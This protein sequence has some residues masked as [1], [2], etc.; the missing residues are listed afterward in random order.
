[1][2]SRSITL[3]R[4]NVRWKQITLQ[5]FCGLLCSLKL[6]FTSVRT[7]TFLQLSEKQLKSMFKHLSM[8][9]WSGF[10]SWIWSKPDFVIWNVFRKKL[11]ERQVCIK[12]GVSMLSQLEGYSH[13]MTVSRGQ[14]MWLLLCIAPPQLRGELPSLLFI[15]FVVWGMEPRALHTLGKWCITILLYYI[16]PGLLLL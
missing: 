1:M 15:I 7:L 9:S 2:L 4:E 16:S 6:D 11:K 14:F 13:A 10:K 12:K 8:C 3:K 5:I